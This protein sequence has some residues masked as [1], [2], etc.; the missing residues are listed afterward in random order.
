[1]GRLIYSVAS[2]LDGYNTDES[3]DYSWAEPTTEVISALT[4]DA[5][6]VSTYLY[7]RRMYNAMA[8]WETDP[9]LTAGSAE[10]ARFAAVWQAAE[11][12]VFSRTLPDVWTTRTRLERELTVATVQAAKD[13]AAGDLTIEGTTIARSAL[14][15]GVV[16]VIELLVC[17]VIVGG[18]SRVLPEGLQASLTLT[19]QRRFS[20]GMVQLT[21]T[22]A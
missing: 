4:D 1:M 20:N 5:S 8:G 11:K 14:H 17:P 19:R 2:S 12:V 6:S 10:L 7:G 15:L 9:S 13:Q 3:G 22:C 18:G 21:Y 16:D